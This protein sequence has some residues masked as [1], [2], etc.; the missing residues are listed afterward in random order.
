MD[1]FIILL[2]IKALYSWLQDTII[3][4]NT[5]KQDSVKRHTSDLLVF[6]FFSS[7][8]HFSSN[9]LRYILEMWKDKYIKPSHCTYTTFLTKGS[10]SKKNTGFSYGNLQCYQGIFSPIHSCLRSVSNWCIKSWSSK[11]LYFNMTCWPW[12]DAPTW[13][14]PHKAC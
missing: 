11:A 8:F 1:S 14:A 2:L 12:Y 6:Q 4:L 9:T 7:A 13:S 5:T 3:R 10:C